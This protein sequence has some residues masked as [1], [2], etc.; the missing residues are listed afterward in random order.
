VQGHDVR[1]IDEL[2]HLLAEQRETL[3]RLTFGYATETGMR[4]FDAKKKRINESYGQLFKP[5]S[6]K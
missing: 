5:S 3:E 1:Q 6:V 2:V 4:A